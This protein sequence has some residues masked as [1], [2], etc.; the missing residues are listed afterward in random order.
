MTEPPPKD[1]GQ[2]ETEIEAGDA[3]K[4]QV[5]SLGAASCSAG[6]QPLSKMKNQNPV[7]VVRR[8]TGMNQTEFG[9]LLGVSRGYLADIEVGKRKFTSALQ[10]KIFMVTG[11][12]IGESN[13]EL[14]R[15]KKIVYDRE[16]IMERL[17]GA[18]EDTLKAIVVV[19][20]Q[21]A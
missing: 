6:G 12:W 14:L 19:L 3:E 1:S 20:E 9:K 8:T 4:T 7:A 2:P 16:N 18:S 10:E 5:E 11:Y 13:G 21:N 15:P 17:A